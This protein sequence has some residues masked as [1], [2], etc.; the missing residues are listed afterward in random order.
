MEDESTSAS[1]APAVP[2]LVTADGTYAT[3]SAF[4]GG[5]GQVRGQL[6]IRARNSTEI[7]PLG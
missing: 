2:K 5:D 6:S 1:S 4:V 7:E 3:Q